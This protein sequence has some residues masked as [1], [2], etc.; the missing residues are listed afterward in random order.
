VR[1]DLGGTVRSARSQIVYLDFEGGAS[2]Q[3]AMEPVVVMRPFSAESISG[4]FAG[5]TS[6]IVDLVMANMQQDVAEFDVTLLDSK[7][8]SRPTQPHTELYFGNFNASFLGLADNVD[9]GNLSLQQE[10][11]IYAEDLR[12]W[13]GLQPSVEEIGL[14]LANIGS[15]ELGHL[16]GLEHAAYQGDLM[17]T[18]GSA[19]QVLEIDAAYLRSRLQADV[20]PV[21]FQ[22]GVATL[23]QNLGAGAGAGSR[24][25]MADE[26]PQQPYNWRDE[27]GLPDIPITQGL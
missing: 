4:R 20:F 15:H 7:H 16:L 23:L 11:I 17:S 22:D 6:Y 25:R 9:T 8:Y 18:A 24:V 10:A 1:R 12:L 2:V 3:I 26:A 13:E 14:A 19:R 5:L 21:G 27:A